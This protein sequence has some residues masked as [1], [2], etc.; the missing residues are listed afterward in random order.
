MDGTSTIPQYINVKIVEASTLS[1]FGVTMKS[2]LF[3]ATVAGNFG[4]TSRKTA[5]KMKAIHRTVRLKNIW[6]ESVFT[7]AIAARI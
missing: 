2:R 3:A 7:C 6:S 4:L 5:E 1:S